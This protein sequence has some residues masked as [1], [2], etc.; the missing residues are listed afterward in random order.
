M[1]A[2]LREEY[3][4]DRHHLPTTPHTALATSDESLPRTPKPHN[5]T[6]RNT[7]KGYIQESPA[8]PDHSQLPHLSI[9]RCQESGWESDSLLE[10]PGC[11]R[12]PVMEGSRYHNEKRIN[13]VSKSS[14]GLGFGPRSSDLIGLLH[15]IWS[16]TLSVGTSSFF[17]A[18]CAFVF[19]RGNSSFF[20]PN[21]CLPECSG[22][23]GGSSRA[24]PLLKQPSL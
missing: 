7:T 20:L 3:T 13:S 12:T 15:Y 10:I 9:A 11:S 8:C 17:L 4:H 22:W 2:D 23:S 24:H 16:D 21:L 14:L 19:L 5:Q 18:K 1:Y 6:V